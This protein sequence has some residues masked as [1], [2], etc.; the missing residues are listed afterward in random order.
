[1]KEIAD[2]IKPSEILDDSTL[3]LGVYMRKWKG[4]KYRHTFIGK[5][6]VAPESYYVNQIRVYTYGK[7]PQPYTYLLDRIKAD[8]E[9]EGEGYFVDESTKITVVHNCAVTTY[10]TIKK[11]V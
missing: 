2:K 3:I 8:L 7:N 5:V 10:H 9:A 6:Y 11:T 1:M 4:N